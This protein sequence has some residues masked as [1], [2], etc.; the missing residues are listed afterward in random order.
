MGFCKASIS[1]SLWKK[2]N[3]RT[4]LVNCQTDIPGRGWGMFL[5]FTFYRKLLFYNNVHIFA[6]YLLPPP[7]PNKDATLHALG[8]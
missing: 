8:K 3:L 1:R 2:G 4:L 6:I 7:P 5:F